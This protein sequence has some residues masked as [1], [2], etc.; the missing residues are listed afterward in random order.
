MLRDL[1]LLVAML[2]RARRRGKRVLEGAGRVGSAV[3]VAVVG[4]DLVVVW[5]VIDRDQES[6]FSFLL[7]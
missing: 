3:V 7:L 2:R 4:T 6:A 5:A 1:L